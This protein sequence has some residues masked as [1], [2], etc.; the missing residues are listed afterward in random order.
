MCI[1]NPSKAVALPW[2][3]DINRLSAI[4]Q[5]WDAIAEGVTE[6]EKLMYAS[7]ILHLTSVFAKI[8]DK[9]EWEVRYRD[10]RL[11]CAG[12]HGIPVAIIRRRNADLLTTV[13]VNLMHW[14]NKLR[15]LSELWDKIHKVSS[16]CEVQAI[17]NVARCWRFR[18]HLDFRIR[19]TTAIYGRPSFAHLEFTGARIT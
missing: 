11:D 6:Q 18:W 12:R 14:P 19:S 15:G 2:S 3:W 17:A 10:M 7:C 4:L 16:F 1:I 13:I 8:V 5:S 9:L